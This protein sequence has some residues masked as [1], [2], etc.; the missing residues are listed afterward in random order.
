MMEL[1]F[2]CHT[3]GGDLGGCGDA[4]LYKIR[5]PDGCLGKVGILHSGAGKDSGEEI[6]GAVE[7]PGNHWG[8]IGEDTGLPM[9]A[10]EADVSFLTADTGNHHGISRESLQ[11]SFGQI[12]PI[13]SGSRIF[14]IF[15]PRKVYYI[16]Q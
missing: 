4:A 1:G 11:Q 10:C 7:L 2:K 14:L 6:P 3:M 8:L 15:I 12:G 9:T 16:C 13:P 5:S